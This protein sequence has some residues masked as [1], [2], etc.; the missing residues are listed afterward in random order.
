MLVNLQQ[1]TTPDQMRT[2]HP[3]SCT[4][5]KYGLISC[6]SV[7]F[8]C[9]SNRLSGQCCTDDV[10]VNS[11]EFLFLAF[12]CQNEGDPT[13]QLPCEDFEGSL[14]EKAY[15]VISTSNVSRKVVSSVNLGSTFQVKATDFN[16]EF[17]PEEIQISM[18]SDSTLLN[19]FQRLTIP[20]NCTSGLLLDRRWG[21]LRVQSIVMVSGEKC[22]SKSAGVLPL[23]FHSF[24]IDS[25]SEGVEIS[26]WLAGDLFAGK[27]ELQRS[28]EGDYF[29]VIQTFT[30]GL[31]NPQHKYRYLDTRP[32]EV[33]FYRLKL[34]DEIGAYSYS[35]VKMVLYGSTSGISIF[36][37]PVTEQIY[38]EGQ[39]ENV[40][41]AIYSSGGIL[42]QTLRADHFP[43]NV[44]AW[45]SGFYFLSIF[46]GSKSVQHK[47]FKR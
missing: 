13:V 14:P 1:H 42:L 11:V 17:L 23:S 15:V 6:F 31:I 10:G 36:P 44:C 39:L 43:L 41:V 45:P 35:A 28:E 2:T 4:L 38:L 8:L 16:I 12:D 37:N 30:P 22:I 34:F 9:L 7:F 32:E 20:T 46:D 33:N 19:R 18:F 21:S 40:S 24:D 25:G 29:E 5:Y 26:W 47:L 27:M 3:R